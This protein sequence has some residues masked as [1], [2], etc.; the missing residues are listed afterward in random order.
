[1]SEFDANAEE[2]RQWIAIGRMLLAEGRFDEALALIEKATSA[3]SIPI[4][5]QSRAWRLKGM[6]LFR[7]RRYEDALA[8]SNRRI[9]LRPAA[10]AG[11]LERASDLSA[12]ERHDEAIADCEKAIAL[13]PENEIVW[14][15][16]G[17]VLFQARRC[18]P[19]R[20][21]YERAVA[22]HPHDAKASVGLAETLAAL[23]RHRA[24]VAACDQALQIMSV[25]EDAPRGS[26][27]AKAEE[28]GA[29]QIKMY[30]LY[31]GISFEALG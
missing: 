30:S 31:Q 28:V 14:R 6:V 27:W 8:A 1:M 4:A 19:A 3:T 17:N 25:S 2:V 16:L 5:L 18:S 7:M 29:L 12:L 20:S 15:Y 24:S 22:L 21:A 23:G 11:Y 26:A 9:E 13:E 10:A